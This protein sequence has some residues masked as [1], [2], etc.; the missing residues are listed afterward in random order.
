[1][2]DYL[3]I[4]TGLPRSGTSLLMQLLEAGGIPIL[5]DS[6]RL[7]DE[8]NPCGYYEYEPISNLIKS[9]DTS[10]LEQYKG[11]AVKIIS[12][13]LVR[14]IMPIPARIIYMKRD[15][16]EVIQSQQKMVYQN[17]YLDIPSLLSDRK[18]LLNT[19]KKHTQ[20][21]MN[22]IFRYSNLTVLEVN[23]AEIFLNSENIINSIDE[24]LDGDLDKNRMKSVIKPELYRTK[25]KN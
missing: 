5:C 14:L 11:Y 10:W 9:S 16:Q 25:V 2:R 17:N 6:K 1:M 23:F 7:P 22:Y 21:T 3:I 24:F 19:F 20:Q 4:V 18:Q 8:Y 13:I 15:L 12:P